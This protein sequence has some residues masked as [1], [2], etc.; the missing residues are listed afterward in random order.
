MII[1]FQLFITLFSLAVIGGVV[2]RKRE[3]VL[4]PR[5]LAFWG[6]FWVLVIVAVWQPNATIVLAHALGIGRGSDLVVYVSLA[7]MF[8]I[9]FRLHIKIEHIGKS[10]TK[11]VRDETMRQ[12]KK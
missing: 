7:L 1:F 2:R 10:I 9:L 6:L 4:G 12:S 8:Y 11:I 3:G 5:G